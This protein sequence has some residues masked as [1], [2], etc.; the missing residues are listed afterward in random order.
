[1]QANID[2][3]SAN[4]DRSPGTHPEHPQ[5]DTGNLVASIQAK[6]LK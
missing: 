4:L 1:M 2:A 5:R 3:G 6:R